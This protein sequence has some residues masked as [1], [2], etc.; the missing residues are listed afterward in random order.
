MQNQSIPEPSRESAVEDDAPAVGLESD[1]CRR[2]QLAMVVNGL[3]FVQ[4][5]VIVNRGV[6]A[7]RDLELV[8]RA[9]PD[10]AEPLSIRLDEVGAGARL[11]VE[12]VELRLRSAF[13]EALTE[14]RPGSLVLEVRR[15]GV[16]L[17]R[18]EAAL[19]LCAAN[20]W[21]GMAV[22]PELLAAFALP[23]ESFV[24]HL[25]RSAAGFLEEWTGDPSLSGY[26]SGDAR[27]VVQMT[28]AIYAALQAAELTYV[29]PPAG[30]ADEGQR[31]RLPRD[32][33]AHRLATCLD[34]ALLAA[35]CLEQA[36]LYPL[37][38][39][40]EGH[41]LCG[42]WLAEEC[43]GEPI[44]EELRRIT[45][46]VELEEL[47]VFD[48]TAAT[49][50]PSVDFD[51]ARAEAERHLKGGTEFRFAID[52]ARARRGGVRPLASFA[53][54][55]GGA[56][57]PVSIAAAPT[58][59]PTLERLAEQER[60]RESQVT[61]EALAPGTRLEHWRR[62]LL[63]LSMRNRLLNFKVSKRTIPLLPPSLAALEDALADGA[64][65]QVRPRPKELEAIVGNPAAR[66]GVMEQLAPFFGTELGA[67]R[68]R[69][70]LDEDELEKRILTIY[71]D[72][73][74]AME[75]GGSN[76]LFLALGF[77][78]FVEKGKTTQ[79]LAP[80]LLLPVELTRKSVRQGFVL[81][82][83]G[84]E[85]RINVTL[86][87]LLKRDHGIEIL[88]DPLPEDEAG[89]DVPQILHSIRHSIR[90]EDDWELTEDLALGLFS[91]AKILLWKD[92][93]ERSDELLKNP[94]VRH[95]VERSSEIYDDGVVFPDADKLDTEHSASETFCPLSA[96]S[97][98]LAAVFAA[99]H[100]KSFVL[101][102]PPGTGKSQTIANLIAHCVADGKSVL[103]VSEKMAALEVVHARLQSIG[104]GEACLELHSNKARKKAVLEQLRAAGEVEPS[105]SPAAWRERAEEIDR[106][107]TKLN[108][109]VDA[110]HAPRASGETLFGMLSRLIDLRDTPRVALGWRDIE[111]TTRERLDA[112]RRL[113]DRARGLAAAVGVG[114]LHPL[115][116][117]GRT[118]YSPE[119]ERDARRGLERFAD[120]AAALRERTAPAFERLFVSEV[121]LDDAGWNALAALAEHLMDAPRV[122]AELWSA[123]A[124]GLDERT[125]HWV[126]L[127]RA[128]EDRRAELA[129]R[130]DGDWQRLP[131]N[132][133][134]RLV[135]ESATSWW[136]GAW[137]RRRKVRNALRAFAREPKRLDATAAVRDVGD[138]LALGE[139]EAQLDAVG[140]NAEEVLGALWRGRASDWDAIARNTQW[141]VRCRALLAEF[142]RA[143]GREAG[144]PERVG[145]VLEHDVQE[146]APGGALHAAL[147]EVRRGWVAHLEHRG[148]L[149]HLLEADADVWQPS[150]GGDVVQGA[151]R[152]ARRWLEH[153]SDA[154]GWCRWQSVRAEL[155]SERLADLVDGLHQGTLPADDVVTVFERSYAE[156]WYTAVVSNEPELRGFFSPDHEHTIERF[157]QVDDEL[158][159]LTRDALRARVYA[160]SQLPRNAPGSSE[161]GILARELTKKSRHMALRRLFREIPTTL[162]RLKPCVLM[163]PLSVAQYLDPS[164]PAFDLVVFDEASQIPIWDA[165]GA[166]ARGRQAVIVGDPKQLPPTNFFGRADDDDAG[167]EDM[168][169]DMESILD[170][171]AAC[172]LPTSHL[173][174]HYRSRHESLIAFSNRQYYANGLITFP[175]CTAENL[176]VSW[177]Y[178]D[179]G[180]F[181]RGKSRTNRREAAVVVDEVVRRLTDPVLG[182]Y[183]LGVVTFSQSQQVLIQDLLEEARRARPD[184]DRLMAEDRSEALFVK[185]LE[186]VQGDERDVI[187]FS[188]GYGPDAAGRVYMNFGPMNKSGGERRLNVAVTRAKREVVVVSSLRSDQI[189]LSRTQQRGVRDLKLF[190]EYAEHGAEAFVREAAL[191]PSGAHESPFEEQV[192]AALR[193]R[194]WVVHAQ[195]GC[196]G[197]RIDL[198][199]VDPES[200]GRYLLGVE[201][202]GATY[203]SA[204]TARDRDRL[205]QLVLEGLGWRLQRVWSTDWWRAPGDELEQL[206]RALREARGCRG[207]DAP[208]A[209]QR[210]V[211]PVAPIANVVSEAAD[212]RLDEPDSE[213]AP[214]PVHGAH[215]YRVAALAAADGDF[216]DDAATRAIGAALVHLVAEEGPIMLAV[217]A[218]R[219][220]ELWGVERLRE[221]ARDRIETI[222]RERGLQI[223]DD[224]GAALLWSAEADPGAYRGFRL[225]GDHAA[226]RRAIS[227]IPTLEFAN[228]LEAQLKKFGSTGATDL[229]R[230]TARLFGFKSLGSRVAARMTSALE[231]LVQAGRAVRDGELVRLAPD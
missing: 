92:L 28:G 155:L 198:A 216:Y 128:Y 180:V 208:A 161:A 88:L 49:T 32:I 71:R 199:V 157:R 211:E 167:D 171:C 25:L 67:K 133:L 125:Q 58:S 229:L 150:D 117:I 223:V 15:A 226:S 16:V 129:L 101:E 144:L 207:A 119:W 214:E 6:E 66:S 143:L 165:I 112:V 18:E 172:N 195:V 169:E 142:R 65:F 182:Q 158:L 148:E 111:D 11:H 31:I 231:H 21:P 186:N 164:H 72:A 50:R 205:R 153:W 41:A 78:R 184:L 160:S 20:E 192:A 48:A 2:V 61:P 82:L 8:V 132:D 69:A 152:L 124:E 105:T 145:Q 108:G 30:F 141:V 74:T 113:V 179:D 7:L 60:L 42:V 95:L 83:G 55:T 75:E 38:I 81:S 174:W 5:T 185:N 140:A 193:E 1:V 230:E 76:S 34:A 114:P 10:F 200:P 93:A 209:D 63:D 98:Q 159:E 94:V 57:D 54:A 197:Y 131:L 86:L 45:K 138:M 175:S 151:E 227:E 221:R 149:Q 36:G 218:R 80:L 24:Q 118:E 46:R 87:E 215:D 191:D 40:V 84:D 19:E 162:R 212:Y 51:A 68:L 56:S 39:V 178:V 102:G 177:R 26:Q 100:G 35:A 33:G 59:A 224:D 219:V 12:R 99:A 47:V 97:S 135:Q 203:H 103:F 183:S 139:A 85:P 9:E 4:S 91:F 96:D 137:S 121:A 62:K 196:S 104:L 23:N 130:F 106:L 210:A 3:P 120:G 127:G 122:P 202:D 176:G 188:I 37:L 27:R 44:I 190:L 222:A 14:R 156:E 110:L 204:K 29:N 22:F 194:G 163:S 64:T 17:V 217:A 201:C 90:D 220:G 136:F 126:R 52:V 109:Y 181:D 154:L 116:G 189:D 43:F 146:L 70:D 79:R 53:E 147:A 77:L 134:D 73:R 170:E 213:P 166:I 123:E 206:E 115:L 89:L 173:R 168:T 228:A 13:F 225:P 107:R 187:L